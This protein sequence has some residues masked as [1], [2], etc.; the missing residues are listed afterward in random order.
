MTFFWNFNYYCILCTENLIWGKMSKDFAR[1]TKGS[2]THNDAHKKLG[3]VW[4][5][6][7]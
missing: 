2:V 5:G 3:T 1:L 7:G 4:K 6:E